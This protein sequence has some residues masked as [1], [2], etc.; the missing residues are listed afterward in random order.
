MNLCNLDLGHFVLAN[1]LTP[2]MAKMFFT[3]GISGRGD[4]IVSTLDEPLI[5]ISSEHST[6]G[7]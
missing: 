5:D 4:E 6:F 1:S 3:F 7:L 2:H